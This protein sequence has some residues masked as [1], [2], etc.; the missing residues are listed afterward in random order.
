M[1]YTTRAHPPDASPASGMIPGAV[2]A[3]DEPDH[4]ARATHT[5]TDPARP[6]SPRARPRR[7]FGRGH[8]R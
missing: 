7:R 4:L 1:R 8:R 6:P 5:T 2:H 3:H